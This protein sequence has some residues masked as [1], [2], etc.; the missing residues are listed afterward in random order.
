M[1]GSTN[2]GSG[3]DF[4]FPRLASTGFGKVLLVKGWIF[5]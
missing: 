2:N 1:L 4:S 3:K 5:P